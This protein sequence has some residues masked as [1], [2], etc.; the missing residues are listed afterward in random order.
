MYGVLLVV[1][2]RVRAGGFCLTR[3]SEMGGGLKGKALA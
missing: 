2:V 1:T 3:P